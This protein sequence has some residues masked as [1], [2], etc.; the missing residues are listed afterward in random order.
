MPLQPTFLILKEK[1]FFPLYSLCALLF[2]F[3]YYF[4]VNLFHLEFEVHLLIAQYV[5]GD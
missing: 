1:L 2:T 3:K 5:P 4:I